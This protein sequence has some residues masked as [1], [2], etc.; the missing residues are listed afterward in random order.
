MLNTAPTGGGQLP[1][2]PH[3]ARPTHSSGA[4]STTAASPA[5]TSPVAVVAAPFNAPPTKSLFGIDSSILLAAM[6]A[7]FALGV[8]VMVASGHRGVRRTH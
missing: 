2:A 3:T 4:A 1:A 6:L 7:V 8:S 5:S